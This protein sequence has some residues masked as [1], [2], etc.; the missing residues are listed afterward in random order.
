M[1]LNCF[2]HFGIILDMKVQ[3]RLYYVNKG[4]KKDVFFSKSLHKH[5]F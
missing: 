3:Y 4:R 1:L 5:M 2:K